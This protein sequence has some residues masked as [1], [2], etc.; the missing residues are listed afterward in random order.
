MN[1]LEISNLSVEYYKNKKAVR[2]LKNLSLKIES[3]ESLAVVGESGCG[4]STL[5]SSVMGLI[6]PHEGKITSGRIIFDGMDIFSFSR[7]EWRA[8]RGKKAGIVFQDPFSSL[9]P[10]IPVGAQIEDA[11]RAHNPELS[12]KALREKAMESLA[13]VLLEGERI[14]NSF[15][16]QLSGGQRQRAAIAAA[17]ANAPR[18][19]IADEPTTSLDVTIQ[20]EVLD[21]FDK[22]KAELGLTLM[23]VTHN[24]PVAAQRCGKIAVMY[25]GELIEYGLKEDIIK[26]PK[27]P[28][29]L[30][31]IASV[32]RLRD[33]GAKHISLAGQPPDLSVNI[34][35]CSFAPRCPRV[36]DICKKTAPPVT[37]GGNYSVRCFLYGDDKN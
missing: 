12:G 34:T 32:P 36:M 20:K 7:E 31:L 25:A 1:L 35:G 11:V 14:Y 15:P 9:N 33:K 24:I 2:A 29:T 23:L 19:L 6:M 18:L 28:Y 26:N 8:L 30:A 5:A 16:H 27:H 22:L 10:V 3:G 37:E 17:I 4:K 13:E 21:L